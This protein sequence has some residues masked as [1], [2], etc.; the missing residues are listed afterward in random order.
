MTVILKTDT[1]ARLRESFGFTDI[2]HQREGEEEKRSE[3]GDGD[4]VMR[5]PCPLNRGVRGLAKGA[6]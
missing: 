6:A 4:G 2:K 5:Y 1:P 3:D